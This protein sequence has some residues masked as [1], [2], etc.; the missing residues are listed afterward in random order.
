MCRTSFSTKVRVKFRSRDGP[1]LGL[2]LGCIRVRVLY[3]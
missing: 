1:G 3:G 2:V